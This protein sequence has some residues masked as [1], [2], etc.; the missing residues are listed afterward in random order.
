M[1]LLPQRGEKLMVATK[2]VH[3][4]NSLSLKPYISRGEVVP[5]SSPRVKQNPE[6][7]EEALTGVWCGQSPNPNEAVSYSKAMFVASDG[8]WVWPGQR[9]HPYD[10]LV[11][12]HPQFF[13]TEVPRD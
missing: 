11:Q 5:H 1:K 9:F 4:N 3:L 2:T 12:A 7:F 10:G 6:A 8:K 13:Y